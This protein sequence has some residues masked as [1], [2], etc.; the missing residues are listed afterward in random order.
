MGQKAKV[1]RRCP[2][3]NLVGDLVQVTPTRIRRCNNGHRW[4]DNGYKQVATYVTTAQQLEEARKAIK[5]LVG[6]LDE[7]NTMLQWLDNGMAVQERDKEGIPALQYRLRQAIKN[8]G[9]EK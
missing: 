2:T 4:P 5:G 3:C 8:H 7:A 9:E 6:L 1:I